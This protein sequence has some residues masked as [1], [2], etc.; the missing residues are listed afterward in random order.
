MIPKFSLLAAVAGLAAPAAMA[1]LGANP[2]VFFKPAAEAPAELSVDQ[3]YPGGRQML[4]S[5]FS[6]GGGKAEGKDAPVGGDKVLQEVFE[7]YRKSGLRVMGPQYELNRRSIS[8]AKAHGLGVIYTIQYGENQIFH[9][10]PPV[11]IDPAEVRETVSRMVREVADHPEIKGWYLQ[12]EELRPWRKDEMIFLEAASKAIREADPQKRPL[13]I[14]D[15][16]HAGAK[17]LAAIAPWVDYLGKGMYANYVKM[18]EN[19]IWCR[20]SMEQQLE[21]I[22]ESGAKAVPIAVPEMYHDS[23][24]APLTAEQIARIPAQVRHD[25]YLGLV[26]GAKGVVVFSMRQRPS[27]PLEA[28]EAYYEAYAG[29]ARELLEGKK[30][31]DVFLFGEKREGIAI[32]VVEGPQTLE[33]LFPA[34]GVK[35]PKVYPSVASLDVAYGPDRYLFLVNSANEPVEI[36]VGGL[37][38]AVAQ[39]E[40]LF[41]QEAPFLVGEGEFQIQLAPLEVRGYRLSRRA[42]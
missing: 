22:A 8:D 36:M 16:A 30:L 37:P 19:R 35:E 11:A 14:Y 15:P 10:K 3:L 38:Y 5:F 28:W 25:T 1:A 17:R 13:W 41:H 32:D 9:A 27:L 7:R 12:P 33:M 42:P 34:G 6:V 2:D 18:Q 40:S 20:W 39:A 21:A 29:V 23:R 4:F 26:S 24:H 31:A